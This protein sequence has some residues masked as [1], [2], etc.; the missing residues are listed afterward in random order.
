[1]AI[2]PQGRPDRKLPPLVVMPP[3]PAVFRQDAFYQIGRADPPHGHDFG[4][5]PWKSKP[6]TAAA[7]AEL[8]AI[9][10]AIAA[11]TYAYPGP[12][13]TKHMRHYFSNTGRDYTID[14]EN[15]VKVV[16]SARQIMVGE[17]RLA[18]AFAETLP[19][20]EHQITARAGRLGYNMQGENADWYFAI[21][22]Y[23]RWGRGTV[24]ITLGDFGI[25]CE[26]DFEYR[27][28]DR[29]N[30]D[31][32]KAV[33][34]AGIEITDEFMGE[35]HRQGL[36]REFDCHG[37]IRRHLVWSPGVKPPTDQVIVAPQGRG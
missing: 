15:M 11:P 33:T 24:R 3:S 7:L 12:N 4:A 31:G 23:T 8:V 27:F 36:A 25:R 14:L 32:D 9:Q 37:S 19:L 30:W 34:I 29:Y 1:M 18:Q 16:P 35:F 5:G 10:T 22:G 20:G 17:F 28:F 13:A 21:G 2:N 26:M 6:V